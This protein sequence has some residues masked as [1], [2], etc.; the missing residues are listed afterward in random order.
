MR[1][2]P[3]LTFMAL[4]VCG[5]SVDDLS[6]LAAAYDCGLM[7]GDVLVAVNGESI[8]DMPAADASHLLS[9]KLKSTVAVQVQRRDGGKTLL[10]AIPGRSESTAQRDTHLT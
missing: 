2:P 8:A 9:G 5:T 3:T 10:I 7:K 1:E 6:F 4:L